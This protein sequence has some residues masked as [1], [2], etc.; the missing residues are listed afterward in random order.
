MDKVRGIQAVDSLQLT[1]YSLLKD[2]NKQKTTTIGVVPPDS[3]KAASD[4]ASVNKAVMHSENS[5]H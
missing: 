3:P 2:L 4:S 5:L 1:N